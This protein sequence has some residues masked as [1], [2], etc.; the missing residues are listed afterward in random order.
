M[1]GLVSGVGEG[2]L[3]LNLQ[4]QDWAAESWGLA[5]LNVGNRDV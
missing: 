5:V 4:E 1:G 3:E 2:M